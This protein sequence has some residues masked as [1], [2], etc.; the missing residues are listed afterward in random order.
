ME[1]WALIRRLVA[2]GVP[3]RQV[4]RDLG[5]GRSTVARA[6][7]SDGPPKYERPEVPTSFTPFRT[8]GAAVAG[9]DAGHAGDGDR[10]A[11]RLDRVDHVVPRPRP[12][13]AA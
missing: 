8:G 3:Q 1:D 10:R 7:A 12:A 5:V 6:V 2:D 9:Q 13:V 11:G 4:A